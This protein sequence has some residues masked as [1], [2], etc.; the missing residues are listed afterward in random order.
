M[1]RQ[2]LCHYIKA[3]RQTG[4]HVGGCDGCHRRPRDGGKEEKVEGGREVCRAEV[5]GGEGAPCLHFVWNE[6]CVCEGHRGRANLLH[7]LFLLPVNVCVSVCLY[8]NY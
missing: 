4:R 6:G 8:F 7:V 3:D 1:I 2:T 5:M